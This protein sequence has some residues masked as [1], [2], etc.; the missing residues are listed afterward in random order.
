MEVNW[1]GKVVNKR[2]SGWGAWEK[3][4]CG[5]GRRKIKECVNEGCE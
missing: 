1:L 5:G 4:G 3:G 2:A